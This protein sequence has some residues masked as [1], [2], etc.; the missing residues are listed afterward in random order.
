MTPR[1][2]PGRPRRHRPNRPVRPGVVDPARVRPFPD[3]R[4]TA[5]PGR[6]DCALSRERVARP[7]RVVGTDLLDLVSLPRARQRFLSRATAAIARNGRGSVA[8]TVENS[9]RPPVRLVEGDIEPLRC[10]PFLVRRHARQ[11]ARSGEAMHRTERRC[12][13]PHEIAGTERDP[14][15]TT[16]HDRSRSA[17]RAGRPTQSARTARCSRD[18]SAD[19]TAIIACAPN[20][21][22]R[23][24]RR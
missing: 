15:G 2:R 4:H 5:H 6:S 8:V 10:E 12:S 7:S 21:T 18:P 20:G 23:A 3:R 13:T 19:R 14:S 11:I 22:L 1:F 24:P 9:P 17:W 16:G